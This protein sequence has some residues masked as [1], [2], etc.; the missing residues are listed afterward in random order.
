MGIRDALQP[1]FVRIPALRA[2]VSRVLMCA[3]PPP[4]ASE[5]VIPIAFRAVS[6]R[7]SRS[8]PPMIDPFVR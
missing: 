5:R 1:P 3:F 4:T 2:L 8:V 7:R 6:W